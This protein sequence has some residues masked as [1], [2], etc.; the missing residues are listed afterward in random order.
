MERYKL[1]LQFLFMNLTMLF[2][3]FKSIYINYMAIES[4]NSLEYAFCSPSFLY[5]TSHHTI[6]STRVLRSTYL[7]IFWVFAW[8]IYNIGFSLGIENYAPLEYISGCFYY[9]TLQKNSYSTYVMNAMLQ[10]TK[11][12]QTHQRNCNAPRLC[13]ILIIIIFIYCLCM[14][15]HGCQWLIQSVQGALM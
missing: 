1:L 8:N 9:S 12:M 10:N 13:F 5:A 14:M 15:N 11:Q 7:Y 6:V 3:N 2:N 4:M